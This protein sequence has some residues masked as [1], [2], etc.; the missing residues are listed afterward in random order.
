MNDEELI[1]TLVTLTEGK[2]L[3]FKS[4]SLRLDEPYLKA[5]FIKDLVSM[6]NTP[7]ETSAYLVYGVESRADKTKEIKG[8]G[9]HP[10]DASLQELV[11]AKVSPPPQ[12][13][14]R[15]VAYKGKSLGIVEVFPSR[16]GPFIPQFDHEHVISRGTP[17]CRHGFSNAIP[18][19]SDLREM[20]HW[21]GEGTSKRRIQYDGLT[22]ID[23]G[24]G[25]FD[26]PSYFPSISSVRTLYKPL[27]Y[28][29][30]LNKSN[31]PWFLFFAYDIAHAEDDDKPSIAR[32]MKE[33]VA[34]KKVLLDSGYYESSSKGDDRWGQRGY[35]DI[36]KGFDFTYA[37]C[38][39]HCTDNE[40]KSFQ[41]IAHDVV[42]C[43]KMDVEETGKDNIIPIV[44]ADAP[45]DFKFIV[46]RVVQAINPIMI[47]VPERE[48]GEGIIATARTVFEIRKSLH[49]AKSSCPLHLLGT[50]NP[51]SI[52][53]YTACGANS[54]DSLEWCQMILDFNTSQ[55]HH[56][57]H[58]DFFDYQSDWASQ[59]GVKRELAALMHNLEFYRLWMTQIHA[60]ITKNDITDLLKS[61]L[62]VRWDKE[63]RIVNSFDLL[64][65]SLPELFHEIS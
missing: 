63:G 53:A 50:G 40:G 32:V 30:I 46:P 12:F 47:A 43:W 2:T 34:G 1:D 15:A 7:R 24:G 64:V 58:Y 25:P 39:D 59:P 28:L 16:T 42:R 9:Q 14:Y 6:A 11:S 5:H 3:D 52:L 31:Y 45:R 38:F 17:Y 55:L 44:H 51:L 62:P 57:K 65:D 61:Y 21:M 48:L 23:I 19:A 20:I 4:T 60:A 54:F 13:H 26:Y 56:M 29:K 22:F 36:L 37:F 41:D 35:W 33:A 49:E 10:D 27:Q 18:T 8:A